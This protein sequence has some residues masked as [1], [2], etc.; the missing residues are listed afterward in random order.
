MVSK[1]PF[2]FSRR[3]LLA[4]GTFV[5]AGSSLPNNLSSRQEA[6]VFG[7]ILGDG[8]LQLSP[9]GKTTR[10]RFNHSMAQAEYVN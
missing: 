8:H 5:L 10:L 6:I 1:T 2:R 9:N 4:G 7:N 3:L